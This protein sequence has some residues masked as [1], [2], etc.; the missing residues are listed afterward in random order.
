M[1]STALLLVAA[2]AVTLAS[3][4]DASVGVVQLNEAAL[5]A[6]VSSLSPSESLFVRFYLTG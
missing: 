6:K 2:A 5:A 4:R 1:R 3:A